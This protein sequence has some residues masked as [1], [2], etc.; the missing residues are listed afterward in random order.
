MEFIYYEIIKKRTNQNGQILKYLFFKVPEICIGKLIVDENTFLDVNI[1]S[2]KKELV[3]NRS[4]LTEEVDN[5]S[6]YTAKVRYINNEYFIPVPYEFFDVNC[7]ELSDV[8]AEV[9]IKNDGENVSICQSYAFFFED[10]YKKAYWKAKHEEF[11]SRYSKSLMKQESE[12]N[13]NTLPLHQNAFDYWEDY[14]DVKNLVNS[15]CNV[16]YDEAGY[17]IFDF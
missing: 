17:A 7:K 11:S 6:S 16:S 5:S 3:I 14:A 8:R 1:D 15:V 12:K 10:G 9:S 4:E 13:N 2:I